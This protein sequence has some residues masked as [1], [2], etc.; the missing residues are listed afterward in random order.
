MVRSKQR[1]GDTCADSSH[2]K[3]PTQMHENRLYIGRVGAL[4]VAL[5]VGLA[6]ANSPCIAS[7]HPGHDHADSADST[8]N[9]S[10]PAP[11]DS[12]PGPTASGAA[13]PDTASPSTDSTGDDSTKPSATDDIPS[14]SPSGSVPT[15]PTSVE[16]SPVA[17][18]ADIETP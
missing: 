4:A 6:V 5:G 3:G 8:A 17:D 9:S 2:S 15:E 12:S 18:A 14:A 13:S 10:D 16:S 7:A 11:S 1:G